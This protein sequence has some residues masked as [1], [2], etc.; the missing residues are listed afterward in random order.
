MMQGLITMIMLK[1]A[2]MVSWDDDNNDDNGDAY[3]DYGDD[4]DNEND[5]DDDCTRGFNYSY[6]DELMIMVTMIMFIHAMLI[7]MMMMMI[8]QNN[9]RICDKDTSR[10]N[11]IESCFHP[12]PLKSQCLNNFEAVWKDNRKFV[13]DCRMW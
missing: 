9:L 3:N 7:M 11:F 2:M 8:K 13:E 5:N 12:L 10:L 4:E 6:N 1:T